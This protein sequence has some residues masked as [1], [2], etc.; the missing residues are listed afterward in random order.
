[1]TDAQLMR[2]GARLRKVLLIT[3]HFPPS[4][5]IGAQACA[6]IGRYLPQYGWDPVVLTV[7][8]RYLDRVDAEYRRDFPGTI[9][10]TGVIPHPFRTYR[11]LKRAIG[12][13]SEGIGEGKVPWKVR[14]G[15]RGWVISLLTVPDDCTGWILPAVISGLNVVRRAG[16][17]QLFS[18]GPYWTNHLV[19]LALAR[20][21]GLPWT[22]HFRDPW[23]VPL[24][25]VEPS[26]PISA[27]SLWLERKLERM[28]VRRADVVVCVTESHTALL[29]QAHPE[30]SADK[31]HTIPN[32]FDGA[33]WD[34]LKEGIRG[35]GSVNKDKF[36]ITYAGSLC[37]GR[38]NPFPL[39]RALGS[40]IDSGEVVKD[41]VRVDL[42]GWCVVA[43]GRRVADMARECCLENCVFI[44]GPLSRGETIRRISQSDLLLLLAE[45]WKYQIPG[46]TYE[47]LGAG[48][49][50]LALA[51]EGAL[52]DL[53]RRSGGAWVI[54]PEDQAGIRSAVREAY[55]AWEA[56]RPLPVADPSLVSQFDRRMLAGRFA[57]LFDKGVI[58]VA[59][60]PEV[61]GNFSR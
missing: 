47:Y 25:E 37:M 42:F 41:R 36:V 18:S 43:Q 48:R 59:P 2:H 33:E 55:R 58:D 32:G 56:G 27:V 40:L 3:Y 52:A 29:R 46:K 23:T 35:A 61:A 57:G 24:P 15:L 16:V 60:K 49:P 1:L 34:A 5:E 28:V 31:F 4:N 8:E 38:R 30:V 17:E 9:V 6:Q 19:G 44:T 26:K 11:H 14:A 53:L 39:F 50:I 21:T 45:G 54:N 20:L 51:S 13:R 12:R 10:R 22:A 7:R